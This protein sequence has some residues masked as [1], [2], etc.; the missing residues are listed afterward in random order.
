MTAL[1]LKLVVLPPSGQKINAGFS[2]VLKGT[3]RHPILSF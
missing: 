2:V 1:C 3:P